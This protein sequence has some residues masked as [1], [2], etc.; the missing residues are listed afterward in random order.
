M[1]NERKMK[2]KKKTLCTWTSERQWVLRVSFP[3]REP[4]SKHTSTAAL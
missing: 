3:Q 2:K 1:N 4:S